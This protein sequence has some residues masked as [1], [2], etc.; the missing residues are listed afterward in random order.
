MIFPQHIYTPFDRHHNIEWTLIDNEY[1]EDY[2][3]DYVNGF[4]DMLGNPVTTTVNFGLFML[5]YSTCSNN[6][7]YWNDDKRSEYINH[8]NLNEYVLQM[9]CR[10]Y[11]FVAEFLTDNNDERYVIHAVY[12]SDN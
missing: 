4:L 3:E 12:V 6:F 7:G 10:Q 8:E 11:M 1:R 9:H 2:S 5:L